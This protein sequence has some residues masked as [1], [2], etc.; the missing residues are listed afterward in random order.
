MDLRPVLMTYTKYP[1]LGVWYLAYVIN[2]GLKE[3]LVLGVW[4]LA[5]VIS[6]GLKQ[7]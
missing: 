3:P 5:Y 7:P 2:T 4:Y 6:T 1:F